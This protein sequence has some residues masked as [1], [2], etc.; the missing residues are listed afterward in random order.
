[1]PNEINFICSDC[2]YEFSRDEDFSEGFVIT[3]PN[4][5]STDCHKDYDYNEEDS[6]QDELDE[7]EEDDDGYY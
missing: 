3:C 1:M 6:W 2:D 5:S 4:C 7:F